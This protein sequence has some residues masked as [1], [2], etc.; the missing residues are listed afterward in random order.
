MAWHGN[1]MMADAWQ[2]ATLAVAGVVHMKHIGMVLQAWRSSRCQQYT[3]AQPGSTTSLMSD[4][5]LPARHA[6][7]HEAC[8]MHRIGDLSFPQ[9]ESNS[10][11]ACTKASNQPE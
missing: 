8:V 10:A 4:Q 7:V 2:F 5:V 1:C 6:S 9:H 11:V 3:H